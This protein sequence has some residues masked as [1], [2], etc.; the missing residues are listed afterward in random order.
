M[1]VLYENTGGEIRVW[2]FYSYGGEAEVPD[3]IE[4]CPVTELD[5]AVINVCDMGADFV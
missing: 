1:K 2:R 5:F 3:C 4:G